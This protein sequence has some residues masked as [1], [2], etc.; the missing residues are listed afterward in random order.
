MAIYLAAACCLASG[1]LAIVAAWPQRRISLAELLLRLALSTGVGLG[2]FSAT[3]FVARLLGTAH[4]WE[5]D[6]SVVCFFFAVYALRRSQAGITQTLQ[7]SPDF[8]LPHWA[9]RTLTAAFAVSVLVALYNGVLR[10]VVHPHG[11]GWDAFAIWN[12]RARFLYLGGSHW[13]DGFTP[14]IAWSH[15]DYPL[16]VPAAVAHFWTYSGNDN[17]Q[18][19]A[20]IGFVFA[21]G[22]LALLVS[23]LTLL[24][25]RTAGM[26]AGLA[27][28]STPFFVEQAT[29][30]YADVPLSFFIL[31]TLALQ[32]VFSHA[33][34]GTQSRSCLMI[35]SGI[36]ASF[37]AWTKNEGLL[38]LAA[39]LVAQVWVFLRRPRH[40]WSNHGP[41]RNWRS[42]VSFFAGA[43]PV[44]VLIA[45]FKHSVATPGDL[46]SS[47]AEMIEKVLTARRYWIILQWFAKEFLRFGNWWIVPGTVAMI[48]FYLLTLRRRSATISPAFHACLLSL[49]LVLIGYFAIYLITPRDLYWHLRFSL[50][51]L[52]LQVW[53]SAIFLFF[54]VIGEQTNPTSP[55]KPAS[56]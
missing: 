8:D 52:F 7:L 16:L 11:D 1:Y 48:A 35:L 23:A 31:A 14:A 22:A 34:S 41:A 40:E 55:Q 26:L 45:S 49:G 43:A 2:I 24:R 47:P 5:I 36:A 12:L 20:M 4:F 3:F 54:L 6:L 44:L 27:L 56:C 38:F 15:P 25:G 50:N 53:P 30:Q 9:N 29:S 28:S 42:L 46:F 33:G 17:P 32:V 21:L 10:L 37:A 19:P 18:I 51:R 13:R 39:F